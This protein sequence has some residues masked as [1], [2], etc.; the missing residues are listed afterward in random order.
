MTKIQ[1]TINNLKEVIAAAEVVVT[2][3]EEQ[4]TWKHGDVFKSTFGGTMMYLGFSIKSPQVVNLGENVVGLAL[5]KD[6]CLDGA[7][8]LFNIREKL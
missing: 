1:T 8:F 7:T 2:K 5:N 6:R 4:H 3:L